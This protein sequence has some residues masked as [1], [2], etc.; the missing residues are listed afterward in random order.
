MGASDVPGLRLTGITPGSPADVAGV[1][2]GDVVV[3]FGGTKVTDLYTYTDALRAHKPGD[4]VTVVV[5]RGG[6]LLV[7]FLSGISDPSLRIAPGGYPGRLRDLLGVPAVALSQFFRKAPHGT[8]DMW[9]SARATGCAC[10]SISVPSASR[11]RKWSR[12]RIVW[13]N[14]NSPL[15]NPTAARSSTSP[16]CAGSMSARGSR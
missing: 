16:T 4:V 6:E 11:G 9:A 1:K 5:L 3:E 7:T 8:E 2:A 14:T 13:T 10:A 15:T 12:W